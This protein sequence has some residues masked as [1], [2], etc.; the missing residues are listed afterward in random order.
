MDCDFIKNKIYELSKSSINNSTKEILS[1]NDYN[2]YKKTTALMI[3][4][5]FG[6]ND[7]AKE[8]IENKADINA[9][10]VNGKSAVFFSI[11]NDNI[12]TLDM[13]IE[14]KANINI[15]D[16]KGIT[17]LIWASGNGKTE[18]V[19]TLLKNK[20]DINIKEYLW[21]ESYYMGF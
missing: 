2:F 7:I 6:F 15:Q 18:I 3:A 10:D 16:S 20:A 5:Y 14:N 9:Q 4:S 21:R 11:E 19:K 13:L 12:E 8:L 17:P 1:I